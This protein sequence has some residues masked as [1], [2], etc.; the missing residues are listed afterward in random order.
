MN[1]SRISKPPKTIE[2]RYRKLTDVE[3]ALI[4]PGRYIGSIKPH[5]TET[6]VVGGYPQVDD[7][8]MVRE[9]ITWNP[10][11]IKLFDE[12]ISNSVDE[13]KRDGSNLDT[14]K[15]TFNDAG[16]IT[17]WDNGGIPVVTHSEHNE[18]VP[19]LIFGY[20]RSGSNFDD[21]EDS[22]GTGQNG[23]GATLTNIFS[24]SFC[25]E[26]C[27]GKK[28]FKQTWSN[29]MRSV[30]KA[31]ISPAEGSKGFTKITFTPDYAHL[32]TKLDEGNIAKLI[33][34][35][36]D[37]AGCN[38]KLKVSLNG[39]RIIIKSFE[40]Y[41]RLYTPTFEYE[42]NGDWQV[43]VSQ[44]VESFQHV[45]FVNSTETV[46]GGSH[47]YYVSMQIASEL[48]A[49]ISKKYKVDLKPSEIQNHL[50]I[51][52]NARI[53]NPRYDS[54][55]KENLI[56]EVKEFKTAWAPSE[57]FIKNIFKSDI[58]K[59]ILIWVEAKAHAAEMEALKE[60][61]KDVDKA[62]PRRVEKF[63]DAIDQLS[64]HKCELYLT[65][66][67][68]ARKS[69]QEARGKNPFIGSFALKGKP[70]N[71]TDCDRSVI[72]DN[73]EIKSILLITGLKIG[74][75]VKSV[76]QLRFGK[77]VIM[78]DQDLDGFH[79]AALLLNLFYH[80]WPELFKLGVIYRINTPLVIAT[81]KKGDTVEFMKDSD[82][83]TWAKTAPKHTARRYKGLGTF[84]T[85]VFK[86]VIEQRE[87]YLVRITGIED[88]DKESLSLAFD[89]GRADDRKEWLDGVNYF[90]KF[91]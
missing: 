79:V 36:H 78:S 31:K 63:S 59:S 72:L 65:E 73:R 1:D 34:R 7:G 68:S 29:N 18:P 62:D 81:L 9:E 33:K 74:V 12:V 21:T 90:H 11:L 37:V 70:L 57:R 42:D 52:I 16:E 3:H 38:P 82:Y 71:I 49:L 87:R 55:T 67:D 28:K 41:V 61:N 60:L 86:K 56:T 88:L 43:A 48:R 46:L 53:V 6:W 85:P 8:N 83:E 58:I 40:D 23:E 54:Q 66:G 77:I 22:S 19:T 89:G 17:V 10:G 39:E 51:F 32:D 84:K 24:T 20:L 50:R 2:A 47:V 69:I 45:S 27:D 26:T 30:T 4:R 15:V 5:T 75:Q 25:V 91:E 13:S 44:S 76:N 14:I 35:V 64:R 80:F